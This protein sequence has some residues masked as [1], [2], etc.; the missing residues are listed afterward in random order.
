MDF[1]L[2]NFTCKSNGEVNMA[3]LAFFWT[4]EAFLRKFNQDNLHHFP[5]HIPI[6][7]LV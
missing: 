7:D 6:M 1:Y 3:C 2:Y 4:T 5:V